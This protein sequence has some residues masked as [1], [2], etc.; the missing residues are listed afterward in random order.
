MFTVQNSRV[1]DRGYVGHPNKTDF[2]VSAQ[3]VDKVGN[4]ELPTEQRFAE[5]DWDLTTVLQYWKRAM[6][7]DVRLHNVSIEHTG[8]HFALYRG[9]YGH[10]KTAMTFTR[11]T[12][13]F[14]NDQERY[15][16][17]RLG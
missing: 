16:P 3:W 6:V 7:E 9:L 11:R 13:A 17:Y 12:R 5:I 2:F 14:V 10:I 4:F 15:S 1:L 8:V